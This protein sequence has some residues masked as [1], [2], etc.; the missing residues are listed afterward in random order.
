ML[1]R[2]ELLLELSEPSFPRFHE[3]CHLRQHKASQPTS[4]GFARDITALQ[5]CSSVWLVGGAPD[6]AV[7][8]LS[9][10]LAARYSVPPHTRA[11]PSAQPCSSA[12]FARGGL[13]VSS[14]RV[15]VHWTGGRRGSRLHHG[16]AWHRQ[17]ILR[18][19]AR[20]VFVFFYRLR[21][22]AAP[23][24]SRCRRGRAARSRIAPPTLTVNLNQQPLLLAGWFVWSRGGL[25]L[26]GLSIEPIQ[27]QLCPVGLMPRQLRARNNTRGGHRII[28]QRSL[29]LGHR[30]LGP[31]L[32]PRPAPDGPSAPLSVD[33]LKQA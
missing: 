6:K 1:A 23:T 33:V 2:L 32:R 31:K 10:V 24:Q 25:M 15:H 4:E 26:S 18:Y 9:R 19:A 29:H 17:L 27:L 30:Q 21:R 11:H 14:Q 7:P 13:L 8:A 20:Y 22:A 5:D 16:A 3:P 12:L 28:Q